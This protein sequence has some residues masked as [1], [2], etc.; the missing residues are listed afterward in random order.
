M[1]DD[2]QV[3]RERIE[4]TRASLA[5]K[6]DTLETQVV[7]TA[8]DATEA[9]AETVDRVQG[10]VEETMAT[11]KDTV[12]ET[13]TT[14]KDMF[15]VE[16]QVERHPWLMFGGALALGYLGERVT[17][18]LT[19]PPRRMERRVTPP[20]P[21]PQ[22]MPSELRSPAAAQ[23]GTAGNGDRAADESHWYD[24]MRSELNQLKGL[25]IGTAVGILRDLLADS[26][27]QPVAQ[28]LT[29]VMDKATVKLGGK[30]LPG[31]ILR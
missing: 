5:E 13:V 1:A 31:P 26:V 17:Q 25:A 19:V 11:V 2:T 3:I 28:S 29:E 4:Q 24:P 12:H 20:M 10:A 8:Q 15:D 16:A 18:R 27:P 30:P 14:V 21:T 23:W 6:L 22:V 9:V 7:E